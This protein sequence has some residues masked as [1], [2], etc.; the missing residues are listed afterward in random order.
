[1]YVCDGCMIEEE[2]TLMQPPEVKRARVFL[3]SVWFL[4]KDFD[5]PTYWVSMCSMISE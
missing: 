5:T 1:M 2:Q 4:R 3:M